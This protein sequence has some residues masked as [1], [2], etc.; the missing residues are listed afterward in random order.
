[1]QSLGKDR[2]FFIVSVLG[3]GISGGDLWRT[4]LHYY[5]SR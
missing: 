2:N 1:L 3:F 4:R 5:S